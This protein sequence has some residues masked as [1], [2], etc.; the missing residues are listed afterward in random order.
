MNARL[1]ARHAMTWV[2]LGPLLLMMLLA[3]LAYRPPESPAAS[4]APDEAAP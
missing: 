1:R 4:H 2:L 3:L